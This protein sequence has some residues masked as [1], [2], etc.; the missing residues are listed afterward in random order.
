[1]N[2]AINDRIE[3]LATR[4]R[5]LIDEL[6][7]HCEFGRGLEW[8]ARHTEL[9]D[10]ALDLAFRSALDFGGPEIA[11]VA[12]GGYGRCELA[13]YSDIDLTVVPM[14]ETD[15]ALDSAIRSLFRAIDDAFGRFGLKVGYS[16]RLIGDAP[17]LDAQTRTS[18]L[19]ARLVAGSHQP[20]EALLDRF[21]STFPKGDFL[22]AKIE[23][24]EA[25]W[26]RHHDTPLVVEPHLKEGAGGLRCFQCAS[27]IGAAIG[28]R[29]A[30]ATRQYDHVIHVRNLLHA[31]TG[32]ANDLLT[33]PRQ[34]EIAETQR[35]DV[36]QLGSDLAKSMES[37]HGEY[38][39]AKERIHEA[40]FALAEGVLALRGEAR[41]EGGA[42]RSGAA[43]GLAAA[44]RLKLKVADIETST[45][46]QIDGGE[47]LNT[48]AAGELVL[49]NLDRCGLLAAILPELVACRTLMPED[50]AHTYTVFEHTFRA[51]RFLDELTAAPGFLGELYAG[52][53]DP[54]ELHL[55]VLIHDAGKAV[56]GRPHSESGE[57]IARQVG[58][59]WRL[60]DTT[61]D[62]VAWLVRNHLEM[63][64][65]IRMRD[66]HHPDTVREFARL[67]T[68]RERLAMLTLLTWADVNAV[69]AAAWTPA[70]DA[71]LRDLFVQT[72]SLLQD[73]PDAEP[74]PSLFRRQA[75]RKLQNLEVPEEAMREFV[76][77]LP[78]HYLLSTSPELIRE[79][80][81][82]AQRAQQGE[83]S[84]ELFQRDDL[85]ATDV[86][87]CCPD[88]P[89]LLARV[90]GVLYAL[91]LAPIG[92]RACTTEAVPA[93]AL[94]VFTVSFGGRPLPRATC[95]IL[96]QTLRDVLNGG[97]EVGDLLRER[98][99]DPDR[100]QEIFK[101]TYHPGSPGILEVRAPRGRGMAY[102]ISRVI[103]EQ[104]WNTVAA[105]VGQ[106]AGQ[107]A[108]AFYIQ[109]QDRAPITQEDVDRAFD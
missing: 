34:A 35:V 54:A 46:P 82:F 60:T 36:F 97:K 88:A 73:G 102:R 32:R 62:T 9:A 26:R 59:R 11:V 12:T 106:W 49:R 63:A 25:Q 47:V 67:V 71:F 24:R 80:F 29:P 1:M 21:W 105:R 84:I 42:T 66:V 17:G 27:W 50:S 7:L 43:S 74:D 95:A 45:T 75:L 103:A 16:Y 104:R 28:E 44:T 86:T 90:L 37:L 99:K 41:I 5:S 56:P 10:Q 87:V 8:T 69:A 30:R 2:E 107:G 101:Y 4:R 109:N 83:T 76:D 108:A 94:D 40:R 19:D 93:V 15:P 23:E 78:A 61:I 92:L 13:P 22:I 48:V 85:Q 65:F 6:L 38:L 3:P 98:G 77:S 72:A 55:A 51:I 100:R 89:G 53:Q 68:N 20:L 81:H 70:Q 96:A 64:R 14:D 39:R 57:E 79:H 58:Q 91:E 31:A 18:L 33:R 52:L